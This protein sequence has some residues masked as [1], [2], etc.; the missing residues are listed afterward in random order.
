MSSE[1]KKCNTYLENLPFS[2][3]NNRYAYIYKNGGCPIHNAD[4]MIPNK[5]LVCKPLNNE[6]RQR[7]NEEKWWATG[8]TGVECGLPLELELRD[9][10]LT[11]GGYE[12]CMPYQEPDAQ[13][14]LCRGQLWY[15]DKCLVERGQQSQCHRNSCDLWEANC[16]SHEI[17]IATG[18]ALSGDGMW[19]QH[20][21]LVMRAPRSVRVIETTE[22]RIAYFGF[23]MTYDEA[24]RFCYEN[25]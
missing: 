23:V 2:R 9:K 8:Y 1:N 18:Y 4:Q 15:G 16:N 6:W 12:V 3:L 14:I 19:R 5:P 24:M 11:F 17:A 10:I 20:S 21:W 22:K 13:A 25:H 7:I